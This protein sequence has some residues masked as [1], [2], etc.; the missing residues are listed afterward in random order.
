MPKL[1]SLALIPMLTLTVTVFALACSV[2]EGQQSVAS[3]NGPDE[4]EGTDAPHV[5]SGSTGDSVALNVPSY[6]TTS[7]LD[8]TGSAGWYTSITIGAD[9]LGLISYYDDTNQVLKIAHCDDAACT[10]ATTSTID[11]TGWVGIDTSITIGA[12]G[13]GLISYLDA[14]NGDLKVA[15]CDNPACTSATTST[16]DSTAPSV[17]WSSSITIGADGLGLI[18]YHDNTNGDLKVAHCDNAACTSATTSTIDS[19][20][21]VGLDTSITIGADGLGLISYYDNTNYDLKVAHCDDTACTSATTSTLDSD[22]HVGTDT[23]ITI[24]ADGLGLISYFFA[25]STDSGLRFCN[26]DDCALRVAHCENLAC[27]S[28][29]TSTLDSWGE[30]GLFTSITTGTDGLGLISYFDQTNS[31]LKIAHCDNAACTSAT[32]S[33]VDSR[34]DVPGSVGLDTSITI[35]AD[36]LGLI[37]YKDVPDT[38]RDATL[39]VAHCD[40]TLCSP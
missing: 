26:S 1:S 17:G 16:V 37:S 30:V 12:D 6:N 36:G 34:M 11:S 28:A 27:T 5:T 40:N 25:N 20:G 15:H 7:T 13:L 23:S 35:G 32:T 10:S 22:G 39:K 2:P 9:S 21:L 19:D 18:S 3:T 4:V 14:T 38:Y 33:T 29:T 8:S 24:G 31:S